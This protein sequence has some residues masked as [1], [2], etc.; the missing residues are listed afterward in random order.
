[1]DRFEKKWSYTKEGWSFIQHC[2]GTG[3]RKSGIKDEQ[4]LIRAVFYT[5][6]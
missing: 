2:E 3:F 4:S 1:M 6:I 5:E